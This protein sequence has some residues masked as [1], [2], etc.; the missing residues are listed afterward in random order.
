MY[1]LTVVFVIRRPS[2]PK[3]LSGSVWPFLAYSGSFWS[4]LVL[5]GSVGFVW[6][7][8]GPVGSLWLFPVPSDFLLLVFLGSSRLLGFPGFPGS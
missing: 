7:F 4:C 1:F 3:V 5:S 8:L 2:A 6:F